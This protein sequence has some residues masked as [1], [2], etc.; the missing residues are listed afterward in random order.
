M[1]DGKPG[2]FRFTLRKNANFNYRVIV[3][4]MFLIGKLVLYAINEVIAFQAA[5]F[6]PNITAK[7]I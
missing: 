7:P 3:D 4:V 1:H 6:L 5:K 2:R